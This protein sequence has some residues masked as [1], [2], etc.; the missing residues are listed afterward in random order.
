MDGC[1]SLD[2]LLG[3]MHIQGIKLGI[4]VLAWA[5]GVSYGVAGR[6]L[7]LILPGF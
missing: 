3:V 4:S 1:S 6:A 2:G 5:S 7:Y